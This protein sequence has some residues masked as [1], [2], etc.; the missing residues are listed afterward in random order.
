MQRRE[1]SI[2][3]EQH[4]IGYV[5]NARQLMSR[6]DNCASSVAGDAVQ[7]EHRLIVGDPPFVIDQQECRSVFGLYSVRNELRGGG[8][9]D[10]PSIGAA[11]AGQTME[12]RGCA[13]AAGAEH[14]DAFS[15]FDIE[16]RTAQHPDPRRASRDAGG[17]ALPE[18]ACTERERH[19]RK[20]AR[21]HGS[22]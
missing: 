8:A 20:V 15:L 17:V 16:A 11:K 14:R 22:A 9:L 13:R 1:T 2:A 18:G 12:E 4:A 3:K 21:C 19:G 7:S 5:T 6:D 10:G